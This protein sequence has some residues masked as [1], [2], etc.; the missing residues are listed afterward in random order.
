MRLGRSL[1][2]V[3]FAAGCVEAAGGSPT[4][5]EK[6]RRPE[7]TLAHGLRAPKDPAAR[8]GAVELG[9]LVITPRPH[10]LDGRTQRDLLELLVKSP[11]SIGPASVGAPHRGALYNSVALPPSE[12]WE[13]VHPDRSWTTDE[14]IAELGLA[15]EAVHSRYPNTPKLFIGDM[16]RR[17]GGYLRPHRSHQSGRDVDVGYYYSTGPAWYVRAGAE[18]L[19][20]PRTWTLVMALLTGGNVEYLFLDRS[21]AALLRDYGLGAGHGPDSI[22]QLFVGDRD[23]MPAIRHAPGHLT[24]FHVRFFSNT[25]QRTGERLGPMLKRRRLL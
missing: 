17:R 2:A 1:G 18:N 23:H 22:D 21:V 12:V 3:V 16:S 5:D 8:P 13:A 9:S 24:H 19:D 14:V 7:A 25:A 15:V 10:P 4:L 20:C 11:A 6:S